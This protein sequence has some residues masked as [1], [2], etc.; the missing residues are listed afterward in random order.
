MRYRSS[1]RAEV[2]SG[3]EEVAV[4]ASDVLLTAG[5]CPDALLIAK[6]ES[7]IKKQIRTNLTTEGLPKWS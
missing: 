1:E 3:E 6:I 7:V 2:V 4:A 5:C